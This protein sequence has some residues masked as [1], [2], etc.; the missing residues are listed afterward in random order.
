[1]GAVVLWG[2]A[3][4]KLYHSRMVY[5]DS[6]VHVGALVCGQNVYVRVDTFNENGITEG[7][8]ITVN[9]S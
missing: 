3:S 1:M 8:V 5:G 6:R 4:D 7:K 2:H 9:N